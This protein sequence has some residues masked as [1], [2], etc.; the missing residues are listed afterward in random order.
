MIKAL[1][2]FAWLL[3]ALV[4]V[5]GD[6]GG[7]STTSSFALL[8]HPTLSKTTIVFEYAGD[9][10]SVSRE[11]GEA[12]HLTTNPGVEENPIFSPDGTQIAFTGEYDGNVDVFVMPATGGVPKRLT[13]HPAPDIALGWTPDGKRILFS[14]PRSAYSSFFQLFTVSAEGGY[15]EQL[16]LPTGFDGSYSATVRLL[17]IRR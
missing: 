11:G 8:R 13:W 17:R 6:A 16:P 14:S 7:A 9:L 4:V 1:G 12:S 2:S 10:W 3:I 15:P 5:S